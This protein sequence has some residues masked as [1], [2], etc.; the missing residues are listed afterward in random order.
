MLWKIS[1]SCISRSSIIYFWLKRVDVRNGARTVARFL[2]FGTGV[3]GLTKGNH[4]LF[5]YANRFILMYSVVL[6]TQA[7]SALTTT[8]VG[9]L[10][11]N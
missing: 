1:S 3:S 11:V 8:I 6:C 7:N 10:K 2:R 5:P 9:C 4:V